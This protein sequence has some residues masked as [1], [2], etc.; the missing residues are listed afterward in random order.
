MT[1]LLGIALVLVACGGASGPVLRTES[2][3]PT[4]S[5]IPTRTPAPS[6]SVTVA[7]PASPSAPATPI[8]RP[9]G[10]IHYV[11][12]GASDTVGVGSLDP[13]SGSWPSRVAALMPSDRTYRNLGVSGSLA[14]QAR[15]EQLPTAVREQPTVVTVWLAVNDLNAQVPAA[16]YRAS[17]GAIVDSLVRD[18]PAR[19]F[20]GTVPDLRAVPAY[21]STDQRALLGLIQQY[22]N[23]I[24]DAAAKHGSRVV[25]VDLFTGSAEL[26]TAM[27]VAADGFH[28][29][30]EGYVLIAQRFADVMRRSGVPL[31]AGP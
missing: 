29:S 11:A 10:A 21:A 3:T 12:I 6:P 30:D 2:P 9:S 27:T 8:V 5:P 4:R 25:V 13:H 19:I 18:T 1:R 16:A 7:P 17:L 24:H 22:N 23:A 28:P 20:V 26:T 31:R 14:D 15:R